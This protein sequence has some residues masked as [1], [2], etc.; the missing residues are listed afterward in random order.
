[1]LDQRNP[2]TGESKTRIDLTGV[3]ETMLWPLWNR[4]AEARRH[5]RL[6]D[7]PLSAELVDRLDYDLRRRFGRP[8]VYHAVRARVSDDLIRDYLE[9]KG[10]DAVVVAL[11]EGLETQ[12]WRIG[13]KTPKWVSVDVP[14]AV[15]VRQGLLPASDS[16]SLVACSALD[17]D[18]MDAVPKETAP[19]ITAAGLLMYFEEA[20]VRDLLSRIAN[21][22][23]GAELFFDTIPPF[24]AKKTLKGF[25]VTKH[26]TA[27]RMPWGIRIIDIPEFV[28]SIPGWDVVSVRSYGEPFPH[29]TPVYNWLSRLPG[30]RKWLPGTLTVLRARKRE[31]G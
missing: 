4:A 6:I 20:D 21:R 1:M 27:P 2:M 25:K 31:A 28:R 13:D 10:S 16:Q 12:L 22:F 9:R 3:P 8:S 15:A 24:F 5:D 29:R 14:E 30:L 23:P 7:D 17:D 26:Y 18:W 11:G 19:L